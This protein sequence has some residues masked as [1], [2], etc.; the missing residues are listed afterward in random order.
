VHDRAVELESARDLGLAAEHLD[1]LLSAV[2]GAKPSMSNS[3]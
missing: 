2:H 3:V 1:Q